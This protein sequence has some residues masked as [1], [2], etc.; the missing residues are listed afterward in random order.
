MSL[1]I[2]GKESLVYGFG[3]VVS[4]LITFLLLPIYTHSFSPKEYGTIS[5]AYAF[6]GFASVLY[7]YG[8]E[9]TT[10]QRHIVTLGGCDEIE[11]VEV[12]SC[13]TVS[14]LYNEWAKFMA[15]AQP[16]I[17]T[18]YNIFGFDF[19]FLWECAEEY[20]CLNK[21]IGMGPMKGIE[22]KLGSKELFSAAM[23]HN[24]LYYFEM[25]GMVT[26]DLLKVIQREHNLSS[27]KLDDVSNEFINGS[28][29][30]FEFE[31][32]KMI[33]NTPSTFSL[34]PGHY[35]AIYKSSIIG[36]EY[37]GERRKILEKIYFSKFFKVFIINSS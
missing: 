12:V 24:F 32:N 5:L 26:I 9:S 37:L 28:I 30:S 25:P 14:E 27:Y 8:M 31:E 29:S 6:I 22:N 2:L 7:R 34:R 13:E 11:G 4:R 16:N 21:L 1:K 19:K 17:I 33:V 15:K 3:H 20:G 10:I 23:G 18:G 35:L 36:K